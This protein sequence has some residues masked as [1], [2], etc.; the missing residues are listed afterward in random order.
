MLVGFVFVRGVCL[1]WGTLGEVREA[2]MSSYL[3]PPW[4]LVDKRSIAS[5]GLRGLPASLNFCQGRPILIVLDRASTFNDL[6]LAGWKTHFPPYHDV[7]GSSGLLRASRLLS[8]ECKKCEHTFGSHLLSITYRKDAG[9]LQEAAA[10]S[11]DLRSRASQFQF[12]HRRR[13]PCTDVAVTM[14][15]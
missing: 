6:L 15:P 5:N 8:G 14:G 4:S 10:D 12:I 9:K 11:R 1:C 2:G 7:S 3:K 13:C